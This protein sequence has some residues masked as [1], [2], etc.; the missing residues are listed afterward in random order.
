[1]NAHIPATAP[2]PTVEQVAERSGVST[3]SIWRWKRD[4]RFPDA[5]RIGTN[6]TRW[7]IADLLECESTLDTCFMTDASFLLGS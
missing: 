5:R 4:G 3:G 2:F 1:M 6:I 7:H